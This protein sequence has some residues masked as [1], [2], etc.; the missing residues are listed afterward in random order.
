MAQMY[1]W[2]RSLVAR[3]EKSPMYTG[4]SLSAWPLRVIAMPLRACTALI[5]SLSD[6]L[7]PNA[8]ACTTPAA[9]QRQVLGGAGHFG[10]LS[11][12]YA[13]TCIVLPNLMVQQAYHA[14]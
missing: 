12:A 2:M 4:I 8:A 1:T 5:R 14:S 13:G 6:K 11:S 3:D 9:C 10:I 7:A